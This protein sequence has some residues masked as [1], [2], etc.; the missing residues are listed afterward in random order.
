MKIPTMDAGD[1][2]YC[3]R[4]VI[5][6]TDRPW[7][8]ATTLYIAR[9]LHALAGDRR[10][11]VLD[12]GCGDGTII[13]SLAA[14]GHDLYGYDLV[15]K[16]DEHA[17]SRR[18]RLTPFLGSAYDDHIKVTDSERD[19]PFPDESFDVVYANQVFEHIRFLDRMLAECAR[20]L[21]PGGTL[22]ANFP[23][24]TYPVE[25]HIRV[26][27]AHWLPPGRFRRRYIEL[28]CRAGLVPRWSGEEGYS[29][30]RV[31]QVRDKFLTEKT[32]YRFMNEIT[33]VAT[34]YFATCDVETDAFLRAKIDL[35]RA[36]SST[37]A[38]RVAG[39]LET[40]DRNG[41]LSSAVTHL[42]NAA[43]CMT[44]PTKPV[45]SD[46]SRAATAG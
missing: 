12:L 23:L 6:A 2:V 36:S 11:A 7:N 8:S 34:H 29:P 15:R 3:W 46:T 30:A 20:V 43:F 37:R 10:L 1:R 32:F 39:M 5:Q 25:G 16:E 24:A 35:L 14:Y 17:E 31:A 4:A 40:L 26:P 33:S 45:P 18:Q 38:T 44:G 41:M 21:K 19:I 42:A 22:L 27:I 13:E 9:R 28:W